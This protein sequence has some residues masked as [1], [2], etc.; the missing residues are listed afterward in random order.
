MQAVSIQLAWSWVRWQ[1][2]SAVTQWY[3]ARFGTGRR[4]RKI[5]IVAVA[6]RLLIAL[7]R[8]ATTGLVP[9]GAVLKSL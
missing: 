9:A 8:Y 2:L 6:R 7:W 3:R 4:A 1:P 5:G